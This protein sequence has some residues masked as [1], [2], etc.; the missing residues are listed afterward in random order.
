M[1]TTY[2][3]DEFIAKYS[4]FVNKIT[5]GT[6][7][8]SGTVLSQAILESSGSYNTGGQW[9]VGGSKLAQEA[10]NFFGIKA[11]PAWKGQVYNIST[12]EVYNGKPTFEKDDFRKYN[13]VED[14]IQD[15]LNFLVKNPRYKAAGVFDAKTVADQAAAIKKAGY[16]TDPNYAATV[17]SIYNSIK[18]KISSV[19]SS[20]VETVKKNP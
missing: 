2:T 1:A 17:S 20:T 11:D 4:P 6:G 5:Q 15:H 19:I 16:A 13:S 3:R 18:G 7:L 8:I 14:S 12:R 10:N 9:K